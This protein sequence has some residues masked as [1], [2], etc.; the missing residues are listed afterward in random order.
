MKIWMTIL[1]LLLNI[2]MHNPCLL[3]SL[4]FLWEVNGRS[5]SEGSKAEY[6]QFRRAVC[7]SR[8]FKRLAKQ[9][10]VKSCIWVLW[11]TFALQFPI[12]SITPCLP[13][14]C[15]TNLHYLA[16]IWEI[17][18]KISSSLVFCYSSA[19]VLFML[20]LFSCNYS[21]FLLL[22]QSLILY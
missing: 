17:W 18:I 5:K 7:S 12:G 15:C 6:Y 22:H 16:S 14:Y 19:S 11:H 4:M 20:V 2:Q 8:I 21:L 13:H 1:K 3:T 9:L 10:F